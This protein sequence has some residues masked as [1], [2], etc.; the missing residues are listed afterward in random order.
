MKSKKIIE[1]ERSKNNKISGQKK[2]ND[3]FSD[4]DPESGKHKN[5]IERNLKK[6]VD[7]K[8]DAL[9]DQV[10]MIR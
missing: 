1:R 10:S 9:A 2:K 4:A 5:S 6:E 7:N 8:V 3:D